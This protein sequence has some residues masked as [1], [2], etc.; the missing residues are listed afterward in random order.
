MVDDIITWPN[1]IKEEQK[2]LHGKLNSRAGTIV[3]VVK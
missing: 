1:L 2:V 3:Q